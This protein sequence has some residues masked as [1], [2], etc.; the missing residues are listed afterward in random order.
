MGWSENVT[1]KARSQPCEEQGR[2]RSLLGL[3]S[4]V[5]ASLKLERSLYILEMER[6]PLCLE[7]D[8]K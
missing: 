3:E 8:G 6:K 4:S 5:I 2:Q 1:C 7:S